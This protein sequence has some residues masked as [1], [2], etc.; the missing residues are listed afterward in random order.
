MDVTS[1]LSFPLSLR[2]V[3]AIFKMA[4]LCGTSVILRKQNS[5]VYAA[6]LLARKETD[7]RYFQWFLLR[8]IDKIEEIIKFLMH[9]IPN[10]TS[11]W[12]L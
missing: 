11:S 9:V 2:T 12:R 6:I 3:R 10:L 5:M 8:F 7:I 1:V 4:D